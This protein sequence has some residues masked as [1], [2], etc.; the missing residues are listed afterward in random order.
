MSK[1]KVTKIFSYL[2]PRSFI[3]LHF[4]FTSMIH[5]ELIFVKGVRLASRLTFLP[6]DIQLFQHCFQCCICFLTFIPY[7]NFE[8]GIIT[9]IFHKRSLSSDKVK[10]SLQISQ[11][12]IGKEW[13]RQDLDS[14]LIGFLKL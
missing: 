7:K 11:V 5:F 12:Y 4:S 3:V 9:P 8:S 1:L 10:L 2:S 14:D 13:Q 6:V